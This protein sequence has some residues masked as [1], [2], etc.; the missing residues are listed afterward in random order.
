MSSSVSA[1]TADKLKVRLQTDPPGVIE[2][3]AP[4]NPFLVIHVGPSVH[5]S[6]NRGGRTHR[7]LSV[8]GDIDLVPAGVPSRWEM[9]ETDTALILV[10]AQDFLRA[11]ADQS[12]TINIE[13]VN[14]FQMRDPRIEHIGWVLK[15]EMEA[16]YPSGPLYM[17][18]LAT[19]LA[20]HLLRHHSADAQEPGTRKG[21]MS[22][23]RLKQ[24]LAYIEDNLSQELSLPEIAAIA[25]MS[26]SHCKTLFRESIGVP[27]HQYVIERRVDRAKAMLSSSSVSIG[28]V[29]LETG[30]AHQSHLA[31]H[32]RRVLGVSPRTVR[33]SQC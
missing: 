7:G 10:L 14:R 29:A 2:A 27:V 17:D 23:H 31:Y 26:V 9:K 18:G 13:L 4:R 25:S 33:E 15:A 16:G 24:V 12:S 3:P 21:G 20:V 30:F 19:A 22:G 28:Q 8:H 11:V 32:M 6:C 5:I 1:P